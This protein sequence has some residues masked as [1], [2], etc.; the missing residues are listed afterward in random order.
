M[1]RKNILRHRF[2]PRWDRR[3]PLWLRPLLL[4]TRTP[5]SPY[6][7]TW[8]TVV[9]ARGL[10]FRDDTAAHR[11]SFGPVVISQ[12]IG[13]AHV[14][15]TIITRK[16]IGFVSCVRR[17]HGIVILNVPKWIRV[18]YY[19][20]ECRKNARHTSR[21]LPFTRPARGYN[22]FIAPLSPIV[23]TRVYATGPSSV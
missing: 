7:W 22:I 11:Y 14:V 16:R 3:P 15:A 2:L 13:D 8:L 18:L 4:A 1:R 10:L 21:P 5:N 23:Y 6:N 17:V 20:G 19:G 9:V 12:T